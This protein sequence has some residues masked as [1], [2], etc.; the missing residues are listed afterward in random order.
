MVAY[1][2]PVFLYSY[3]FDTSA[4]ILTIPRGFDLTEREHP[5]TLDHCQVNWCER[6]RGYSLIDISNC[7]AKMRKVWIDTNGGAT[8]L[9]DEF[10][11]ENSQPETLYSDRVA[12]CLSKIQWNSFKAVL[13]PLSLNALG[14]E[15]DE[16]NKH[17]D[18]ENV[19]VYPSLLTTRALLQLTVFATRPSSKKSMFKG[20]PFEKDTFKQSALL[21]T[22]NA[23]KLFPPDNVGLELEFGEG[24]R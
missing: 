1:V 9:P 21:R 12:K 4:N 17:D 20:G 2:M 18:P 22:K 19:Y 7:L 14:E 8:L 11:A 10:R 23:S 24:T 6:I 5:P 16:S 13:F 15:V 3:L